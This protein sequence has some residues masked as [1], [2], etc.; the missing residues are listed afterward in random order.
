[1]CVPGQV[2]IP[3]VTSVLKKFYFEQKHKKSPQV[4]VRKSGVGKKKLSDSALFLC[5]MF[6]VL[7][8]PQFFL[9]DCSLNFSFLLF[10]ILM[11]NERKP[12]PCWSILSLFIH[13]LF[14]LLFV[15]NV[16]AN[17]S[18]RI[19]QETCF[20]FLRISWILCLRIS[21]FRTCAWIISWHTCQVFWWILN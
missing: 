9:P 19:S 10:T 6:C 7:W 1:M 3:K 11:S 14:K 4:L 18:S 5:E 17:N 20:V 21:A 13:F 2:D 15:V 12:Y 16:S 8:N